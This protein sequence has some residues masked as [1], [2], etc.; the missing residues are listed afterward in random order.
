LII[1]YLVCLNIVTRR[2]VMRI[3]VFKITLKLELS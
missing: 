3:D 2:E 1:T